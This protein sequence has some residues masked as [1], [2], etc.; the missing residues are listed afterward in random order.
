MAQA[1]TSI[2]ERHF[3]VAVL[4]ELWSMSCDT[5]QKWFED[6]P[7]VVKIGNDGSRGKRRKI[8]LRIPESVALKVYRERTR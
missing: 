1:E 3:T 7:G 6:V 2:L 8:T 4:A 5:I